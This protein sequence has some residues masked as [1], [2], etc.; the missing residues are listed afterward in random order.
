MWTWCVREGSGPQIPETL[1]RRR[2]FLGRRGESREH[3]GRRPWAVT[4][5]CAPSTRYPP[6][7]GTSYSWLSSVSYRVHTG[8]APSNGDQ[9][10][11]TGGTPMGHCAL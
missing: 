2:V 4:L 10:L 7:P 11:S 5:H 6:T 8:L 1:L 9:V 3:D